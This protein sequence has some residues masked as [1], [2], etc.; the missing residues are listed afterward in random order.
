MKK[1]SILDAKIITSKTGYTLNT[2]VVLD[3][4]GKALE[5]NYRANVIANAL[6][7][8]LVQKT[9]R[10]TPIKAIS[11][12]LTQ[13]KFR[14]QVSYVKAP[15]KNRTMLE[16]VALDHPGLLVQIAKVF[17][18]LKLQ[19]HSAKITTFGEKAEDVFMLSN[20]NNDALSTIEQDDL[21]KQLIVA[22][23]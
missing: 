12:K 5:D 1:L 20:K 19:I 8:T 18:Q 15:A 9:Y 17:Q 7:A 21:S 10:P 23:D 4:H 2:F 22:L 16:L 3:N 13:F 6:T 14:T 11:A